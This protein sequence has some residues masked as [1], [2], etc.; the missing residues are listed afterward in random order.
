[1]LTVVVPVYRVERYVSRCLDSI[2]DEAGGEVEVV[3]I[4]D[5]SPDG[6]SEIIDEYAR[7]DPRVKVV[8][9]AANVGLG[10]ARNAGLER[11]RG[12]YVWFVDSD[13]WLPAGTTAEVV[14]RLRESRPDVL[15]FDHAEVFEDGTVAG[16]G[17]RP[18]PRDLPAVLRLPLAT[19][20]CTKVIRRGLLEE[21]D[22]RF[23]PGW[24]EDCAFSYPLLL[25]A[26]GRIEVLDRVCYFYR[27]RTDGAITRSVSVRHFD[28][29]EQYD[30]M[31]ARVEAG[32]PLRPLLFRLAIDHLLVIA[33]NDHRLPRGYR[34]RFF[35]R[36]ALEFRRRLPEG[37]YEVPHGLAGLK[38]RLVRANAYL[39][40]AALR[41]ARRLVRQERQRSGEPVARPQPA[42]LVAR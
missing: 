33:G 3:A 36:T 4:D 29:F 8:H 1:V 11:A 6:S 14:K 18:L 40:Y 32:H 42:S 23:P 9:L 38:H 25:A 2:L 34:R 21:I 24:Y 16:T 10:R 30:R 22:L 41:L 13:D 39:P 5:H 15:V 7:R 35:L 20:A 31:W 27:Q 26:A 28:I 37:G 17:S 12:E 19:S